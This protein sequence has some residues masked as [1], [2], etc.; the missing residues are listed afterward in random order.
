[1][2]VKIMIVVVA[3]LAAIIT[4][5]GCVSR[6]DFD[7][8]VAEFEAAQA[9]IVLLQDEQDNLES[10]YAEAQEEINSLETTI[11]EARIRI[12]ELESEVAGLLIE[13][14]ELSTID[15]F[16]LAW[17]NAEGRYNTL[18]QDVGL[19]LESTA[20]WL[21]LPSKPEWD[22]SF[23]LISVTLVN[24]PLLYEAGC[25]IHTP[26][27][28]LLSTLFEDEVMTTMTS[29]GG[30]QDYEITTIRDEQGDIIR[31]MM[32]AGESWCDLSWTINEE[33]LNSLIV[34]IN[35]RLKS[36]VWSD[37]PADFNVL[38]LDMLDWQAKIEETGGLINSHDQAMAFLALGELSKP[39]RASYFI[40]DWSGVA[41]RVA[42]DL[43]C[44][45]PASCL[46]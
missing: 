31:A 37:E 28:D 29:R 38:Y 7:D 42:I 12:G 21:T 23:R 18:R 25:I 4:F 40:A 44:G 5:S 1:V 41:R 43:F 24:E 22:K 30:V 11:N 46:S 9:E 2:K 33:G 8:L 39:P 26:E 35:G 15:A 17:T 45:I 13:I 14:D 34:Q 16:E 27:H 6:G 20:P 32:S 3:L 36:F 19:D 10:D